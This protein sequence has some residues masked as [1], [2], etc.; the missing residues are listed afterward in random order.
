MSRGSP[1]LSGVVKRLGVITGMLV[2]GA[3]SL[4][5]ALTVLMAY[6]YR[7]SAWD[8]DPLFPNIVIIGAVSVISGY[9]AYKCLM[10][11]RSH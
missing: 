10:Y 11:A 7:G 4:F 9:L 2:A 3:V 6:A 5:C 8:T 1:Y